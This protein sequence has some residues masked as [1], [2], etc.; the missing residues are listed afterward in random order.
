M[1]SF[2]TS[3]TRLSEL[4]FV[5]NPALDGAI[6]G[7]AAEIAQ[8]YSVKLY[9][10]AIAGNHIHANALFP[11]ANR[12]DF[13]RDFNS[14]IHREV[15]RHVAN[16]PGGSLFGRRFSSEFLP[17][18]PDIEEYFFYT[19]LQ[20]VQDGL[21]PRISEYPSYNCFH[22]A[23]W[24]IE[25]KYTVIDWREY[26]A[27][28]KRNP[29]VH[30][31]N[32]TEVFTLRY[33]RLP[34]YEKLS[35]AEYAHMM[36]Q[37]LE[38]RRRKIVADRVTSGLGFAGREEVLQTVPGSRPYKTKTSNINTHRPRVLSVCPIRR[39]E[40][41][42]WYFEMY[43]KYKEASKRY[44][45]GELDVEFPEGTYRPSLRYFPSGAPP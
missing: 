13:M 8:R 9:A 38:A 18:G 45:A 15:N 43:F 32:Y 40:T 19:V 3:R 21:V 28:R 34:G 33:E 23:I 41:K 30:I 10:L 4:W 37:K 12:A 36:M 25:R 20:A 14:S 17:A 24:G 16:F 11:N 22:D 26:N 2:I 29:Q 27:A 6:M 44:R 42:A 39:A 7:H 1:A 31:S 5:N 35:Q